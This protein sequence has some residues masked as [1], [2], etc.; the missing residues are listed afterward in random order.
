LLWPSKKGFPRSLGFF[1]FFIPSTF[2]FAYLQAK[3]IKIIPKYRWSENVRTNRKMY[4]KI[5]EAK[6]LPKGL[7]I[8]RTGLVS[9]KWETLSTFVVVQIDGK[10]VARTNTLS[11]NVPFPSLLSNNYPRIT[12]ECFIPFFISSCF[13][14]KSLLLMWILNLITLFSP[15]GP[16]RKSKVLLL[17]SL[18]SQYLSSLLFNVRLSSSSD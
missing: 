9:E 11:K 17:P 4:I 6:D 12:Q 3:R 15:F 1:F 5:S 18:L 2:F 16:K 7:N 14:T 8:L 13:G 10:E